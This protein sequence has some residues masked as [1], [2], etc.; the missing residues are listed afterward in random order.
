MPTPSDPATIEIKAVAEFRLKL[1]RLSATMLV[2]L[3]LRFVK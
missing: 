3:L 2:L 1:G